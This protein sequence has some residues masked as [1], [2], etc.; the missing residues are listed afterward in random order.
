MIESSSSGIPRVY[1]LP[2]DQISKIEKIKSGVIFRPRRH[3]MLTPGGFS[4]DIAIEL[5]PEREKSLLE[6]IPNTVPR[7]AEW[8]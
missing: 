4:E 2:F 6:K 7:S 8:A 1:S 3:Y 5:P